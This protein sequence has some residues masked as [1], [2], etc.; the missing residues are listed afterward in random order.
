MTADELR[1]TLRDRVKEYNAM[2]S[3]LLGMRDLTSPQNA[4]RE[5]VQNHIEDEIMFLLTLARRVTL[6]GV[7]PGDVTIK[8][9]EPYPQ[10][11]EE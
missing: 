6:E 8:P 11:D 2:Q 7:S 3:T 1:D 5:I 10:N 9:A 4:C